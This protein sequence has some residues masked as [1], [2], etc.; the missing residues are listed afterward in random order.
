[1]IICIIY[2]ALYICLIIFFFFTQWSSP[3]FYTEFV[4]SACD[5]K[6]CTRHSSLTGSLVPTLVHLFSQMLNVGR[7]VSLTPF[8]ASLFFF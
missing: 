2:Y 4:E 3:L 8:K 7:V 1:M 6:L 5:R